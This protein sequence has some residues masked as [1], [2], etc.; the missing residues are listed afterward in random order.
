MQFRTMDEVLIQIYNI[1]NLESVK[2]YDM[3]LNDTNKLSVVP[4]LLVYYDG[5]KSLNLCSK[6]KHFTT[7]AKKVVQVYKDEKENILEDSLTDPFH[8]NSG[9]DIDSHSKDVIENGTLG[10]IHS[11]YKFYD[12]KESFSGSLLFQKDEVNLLLPIIQYHI[13]RFL[14]ITEKTVSLEDSLDGYRDNYTINGTVDGVPSIFPL[15]YDKVDDNTYTI[16]IGNILGSTSP[17]RLKICFNKNRIEVTVTTDK[18]GIEA[19]FTYSITNG[20]IKSITDI[21]SNG[22]T[23]HYSN[24]D[25]EECENSLPNIANLD[26]TSNFKWFRL[27]WS[28]YYGIDTKVT[29]ISEVEKIVEIGSMYLGTK[30][31][32]FMKKEFLSK[33][34]HRKTTSSVF[35]ETI[36]L[37]EI[38]KNTIGICLSKDGTY[39]IETCFLDTLQ[40]S[41]YYNENLENRFFYHITKN[42]KGLAGID[43]KSLINIG[44]KDGILDNGDILNHSLI[45]KLL[46][47][48][49]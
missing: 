33:N 43:G 27:P 1:R 36:S 28:A 31:N 25:L 42:K 34:F 15:V 37:D 26:Q 46:Q 6:D 40:S 17:I 10:N 39:L 11:L 24:T 13:D 41:G 7:F 9:I 20:T 3:V 14:S 8:L 12:E 45:L 38:A 23:I 30:D 4:A 35:G 16:N 18:Y 5:G 21:K 49:K 22:I 29:D 2:L 44:K 19:R 48:G 47:G 32:S